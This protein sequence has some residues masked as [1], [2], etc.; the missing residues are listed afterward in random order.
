MVPHP[1]PLR[2]HQL[3]MVGHYLFDHLISKHVNVQI[4]KLA[5]H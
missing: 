3:I 1:H 5:S 4:V 2:H